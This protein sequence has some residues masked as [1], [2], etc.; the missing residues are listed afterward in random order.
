[1]LIMHLQEKNLSLDLMIKQ[2]EFFLLIKEKVEKF[3]ME[4]ECKSKIFIIK[5][6]KN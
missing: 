2:L 5:T 1:M 3:I 4:N 6:N